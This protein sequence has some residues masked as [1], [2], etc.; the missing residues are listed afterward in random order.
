MKIKGTSERQGA[1]PMA[2]TFDLS[3]PTAPAAGCILIDFSIN[4]VTK[5][6]ITV[7]KVSAIGR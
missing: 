3:E 5:L 1:S 4:S 7:D 6:A 2:R